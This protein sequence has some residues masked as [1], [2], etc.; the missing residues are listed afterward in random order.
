MPEGED[1]ADMLAGASSGS[2]EAERFSGLVDAAVDLPAFHARTLLDEADLGSP[3]GRDRALDEVVPVLS[4]MGDSI[5]RDELVREVGEK[6]GA[7]PSLVARRL[8]AAG[9]G[10]GRAPEREGGDE[11]VEPA[12][13]PR[14]LSAHEIYEQ[15]LLA[16]CIAAPA[17]GRDYLERLEPD[18]MS[19]PLMAR[20]RDWL[21]MQLEQPREGLPADDPDLVDAVTQLVVRSQREPPSPDA[22][23]LNFLLLERAA[24]ERQ[25]ATAEANGG[26]PPVELQKRRAQLAEKIAHQKAGTKTRR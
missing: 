11:P 1:P 18:Y 15:W 10:R 2:A 9:R 8:A 6:L 4:S 13:G 19:S 20:V 7:D 17:Y 12:P 24:V 26:D 25:I 23:E 21:V 5:T 14:A 3:A 16:M 22:M